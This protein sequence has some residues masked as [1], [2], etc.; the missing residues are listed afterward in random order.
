MK[1]MKGMKIIKILRVSGWRS[2]G[3]GV[4]DHRKRESIGSH[5][6]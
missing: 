6:R 4:V 3:G 5:T 1:G 2:S